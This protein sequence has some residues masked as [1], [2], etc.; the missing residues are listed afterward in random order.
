MFIG[1][2]PFHNFR[3][4]RQTALMNHYP[5]RAVQEW[6]GNSEKVTREQHLKITS[7]LCRRATQKATHQ[8]GA[9]RCNA[10]Q[11]E[12]ESAVSPAFAKD[13]AVQIPPRGVEPR[14]SD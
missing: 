5:A 7:D 10:L 14:F 13:T 3:S 8:G 12:K 4:S 6:T 1:G 9:I 11:P 2:H